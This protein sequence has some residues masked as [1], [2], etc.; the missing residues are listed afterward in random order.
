VTI[1]YAAGSPIK[2]APKPAKT[3]GKKSTIRNDAPDAPEAPGAPIG[4]SPVGQGN[5]VLPPQSLPVLPLPADAVQAERV[6]TQFKPTHSVTGVQA[7]P[8]PSNANGI[9]ILGCALLAAAVLLATSPFAYSAL[10]KTR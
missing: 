8:D 7:R 2:I 9:W 3:G 4:F 5:P 6:T 10:R 1:S